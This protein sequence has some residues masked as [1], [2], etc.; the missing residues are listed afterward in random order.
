[1][2]IGLRVCIIRDELHQLGK[3]V[4]QVHG[5]RKQGINIAAAR[6][7]HICG[8]RRGVPL[9]RVLKRHRAVVWL[10]VPIVAAPVV[11]MPQLLQLQH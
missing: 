10:R 7:L 8:S 2:A 11:G 9:L 3:R 4:A 1:M 6:W 5:M